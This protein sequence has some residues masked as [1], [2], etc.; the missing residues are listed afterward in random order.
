MATRCEDLGVIL[1]VLGP[2]EWCLTQG[3]PSEVALVNAARW[4]RAAYAHFLFHAFLGKE[5]RD[6]ITRR[7][8][9]VPLKI[10]LWVRNVEGSCSTALDS[11]RAASAPNRGI[12]PTKASALTTTQ[13]RTKLLALASSA[14][15]ASLLLD[16]TSL[17]VLLATAP[18]AKWRTVLLTKAPLRKMATTCVMAPSSLLLALTVLLTTAPLRDAA[19]TCGQAASSLLLAP[20]CWWRLPLAATAV[21]PQRSP[22]PH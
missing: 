9:D 5:R 14:S 6:R 1:L 18:L 2:L 11:T 10:Q 15:S 19:T 7:I 21:L 17:T 16:A 3:N 12:G 13:K 4:P 20:I 22:E 8:H